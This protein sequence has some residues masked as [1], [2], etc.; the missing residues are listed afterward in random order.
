MTRRTL[1]Q[2]G[3]S[4]RQQVEPP[5]YATKRRIEV[6]VSP[7]IWIEAVS[8][9]ASIE[10][11]E[12]LRSG[13][14]VLTQRPGGIARVGTVEDISDDAFLVWVRLDAIGRI[15]ITRDDDVTFWKIYR[16]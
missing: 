12:A 11:W 8:P 14:R 6:G 1:E 10:D 7:S 9:S 3:R 5:P 13:N 4:Y 16:Q 15:L 2:E